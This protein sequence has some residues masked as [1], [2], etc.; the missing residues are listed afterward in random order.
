RGDSED[1]VIELTD[2]QLETLTSGDEI[3]GLTRAFLYAG[4]PSVLSSLWSVY[5]Q[6]TAD[7]M[8][9]FYEGIQADRGKAEALRDAQ[10]KIM[11]TPG[12]EHPVYWAAFNLM[13][14]WR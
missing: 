6:A 14:D 4:T 11:N 5:S 2:E 13:G 12:Y 3:S 8:V 10:L 1:E 7:L 9:A